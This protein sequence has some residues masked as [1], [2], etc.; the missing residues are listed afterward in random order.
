MKKLITFCLLSFTILVNPKSISA[1]DQQSKATQIEN[2]ISQAIADMQ[3]TIVQGPQKINLTDQ[4]TLDLPKGYVFFP[5]NEAAKYMKALGNSENPNL[6]GMI[7]SNDEDGTYAI[8][9]KYN[10]DGYVRE[11][12]ADKWNA[13][14]LLKSFQEGTEEANKERKKEGHDAIHVLGWIEKPN[15]DKAN[16]KLIWSIE[17]KVDVTPAPDQGDSVS[18]VNYNT[19]AFGRFGYLELTLMTSKADVEKNK[20]N[21]SNILKAIHFNDG[22]RYED[23]VEGMDKAAAYGLTALIAGAAAKKL[24]FLALAGVFL[25]KIWKFLA[26]GVVLAFSFIR[27]FFSRKKDDEQA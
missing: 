3:K 5:K 22:Y 12:D 8:T 15:Y 13:D 10:P 21:A 7:M 9:I 25:L 23:Y 4:A 19:Y 2:N 16:H 6:L 26:L 20:V 1:N 18:F 14:E 11:D 24:G 27:R 17:G